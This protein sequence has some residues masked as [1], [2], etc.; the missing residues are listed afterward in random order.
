MVEGV[1]IA[2]GF[3]SRAGGWKMA[4]NIGGI[5]VIER[6]VLGMVQN[7]SRIFVIGGSRFY[8][9]Q[10][11]L[12]KQKYPMVELIFN[13]N[14]HQGMFSS[15][16]TGF[17]QV[18]ESRFYFIPGDYPLVSSYVYE[19]TRGSQPIYLGY[20]EVTKKVMAFTTVKYTME[21]VL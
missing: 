10:E 11:L 1:I 8:L 16:L 14:Y 12:P 18:R 20:I 13:R 21:I 5:T 4:F 15:V 17:R 6:C 19:I 2:A 3:S 7:C 9:L